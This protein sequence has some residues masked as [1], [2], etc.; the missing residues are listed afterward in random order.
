MTRQLFLAAAAVL[1]PALGAAEGFT[2]MDL[3]Q[4]G[5]RETCMARAL[6]AMDRYIAQHGGFEVS[7]TEWVTYG[8]DFTPGDQD[9]TI[10]CPWVSDVTVNAF[11]IVHGETTDEERIFTAETL[12]RFFT[13][14]K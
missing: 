12:E 8:W 9:V 6:A 13:A 7:Q 1:I 4:F 10:M 11:L 14:T 3:G 2:N 5:D